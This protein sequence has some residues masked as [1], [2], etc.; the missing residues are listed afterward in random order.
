VPEAM[1]RRGSHSLDSFLSL[2]GFGN[3]ENS[4]DSALENG[5]KISESKAGVNY[6][7][8]GFP[9]RIKRCYVTPQEQVRT[10]ISA[11]YDFRVELIQA[12]LPI[13]DTE[14]LVDH[15]A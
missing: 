14:Q 12:H 9:A 15:S 3:G 10:C 5:R 8:V 6:G 2:L 4:S 7:A 13:R 1:L 11:R